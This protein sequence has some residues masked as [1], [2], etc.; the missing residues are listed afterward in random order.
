MGR[1]SEMCS[2]I[3]I[4]VVLVLVLCGCMEMN[5]MRSRFDTMGTCGR[6]AN[7][8]SK[9]STVSAKESSIGE[10][11]NVI[12]AEF[13]NFAKVDGDWELHADTEATSC[14]KHEEFSQDEDALMQSFNSW[15]ADAEA[16]AKFE[17]AAPDKNMAKKAAVTRPISL[18]TDYE[19][20]TGGRRLGLTS[21]RD[22]YE[23][24]KASNKVVFSD[25]C[26]EWGSSDAH[27]SA[28]SKEN[29]DCGRA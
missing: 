25:K 2:T 8:E 24:K 23:G 19:E 7:I 14:K 12:D 10:E 11:A 6:K 17:E 27:Y 22:M 20:P 28:R 15:E 1:D 26:P 5:R 13:E 3:I 4:M 16:T 29:L 9:A 18:S 21:F